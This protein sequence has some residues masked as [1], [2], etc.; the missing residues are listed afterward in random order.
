MKEG[1]FGRTS[2][3]IVKIVIWDE[4]HQKVV[5]SICFW[6]KNYDFGTK[7]MILGCFYI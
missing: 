6:D 3:M 2:V 4:N 1:R 7:T 5:I